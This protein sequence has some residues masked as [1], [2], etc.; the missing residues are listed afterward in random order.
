M[1]LPFQEYQGENSL[2]YNGTDL[3]SPEM[4][5]AV[6]AAELAPYVV[7]VNRLLAAKGFGSLTSAQLTGQINQFKALIDVCHLHG[8]AVIFDVVYN[9]AGGGFDDQSM[10]FFDR[11]S[12]GDNNDSLYFTD[13]GWAGGLV[14]AYWNNDVKQY[15]IDNAK[16]LYEEYRIDGLRFDEVSVMDRFGGWTTCQDLT[17]T[18][19]AAKPEAIQIA[20][21]WPVNSWIVRDRG[22]GGAGFDATWADGVRDSVRAAITSASQGASAH[23]S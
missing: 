23:V 6:P 7:R 12:Q 8:I 3:F 20:E 4:D 5:Y 11:L 22:E 16:F 15:L 2:G 19:R 10:W 17:S 13:Q 14:F 21:Y 9:H 18:L 1:P